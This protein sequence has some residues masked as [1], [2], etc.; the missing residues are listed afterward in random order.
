M[1]DNSKWISS[2]IGSI[3]ARV[4][5]ILIVAVIFVYIFAYV[6]I[7]VE[8]P[9]PAI[10]YWS[11]GGLLVVAWI[12]LSLFVWRMMTPAATRGTRSS[13]PDMMSDVFITWRTEVLANRIPDGPMSE[14]EEL[15]EKA[16]Q[17]C[18]A[19]VRLYDAPKIASHEV[20][21]NVFLFKHRTEGFSNHKKLQDD[22]EI[23]KGEIGIFLMPSELRLK[24]D[25]HSDEKL[26]LRP[27]NGATG[28]SFMTCDAYVTTPKGRS[29]SATSWGV[30]QR[31][32]NDQLLCLHEDLRWIITAPVKVPSSETLVT[33]KPHWIVLAVVNIDGLAYDVN[34]RTLQEMKAIVINYALQMR[35][36]LE[37]LP[38]RKLVI[39]YCES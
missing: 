26:R 14:L 33:G 15:L 31:L 1:S 30:D 22:D 9:P 32:T 11:I 4:M 38:R 5:A 37:K 18:L 10:V 6:L 28:N 29:R 25:H 19:A 24:M 12:V 7:T 8:R 20:R 13:H 2:I 35:P 39:G 34:D 21:A 23:W 36:I 17:D 3:P 27:Y 16:R